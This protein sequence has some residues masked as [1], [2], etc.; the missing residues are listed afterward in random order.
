MPD[1][2]NANEVLLLEARLRQNRKSTYPELS[3]QDYFLISS[4][5]T[6]LSSK[7]LSSRQIEDGIVDGADDGGI[8][9]V[10]LFVDGQLVEDT[11]SM[12][13]GDSPQIE[14]E[15]IQAKYES[16]FKETTLQRLLDHL[17]ILLQLE[18][19]PSLRVEF[20][21]RVLEKFD[22]FRTT[23]LA[24][25]NKFPELTIRIRYVTKSSEAP[26][27]KVGAKQVR[28]INKI[29]DLYSGSDIAVQLVG[30]NDLN[31]LARQRRSRPSTLR[32]SEG[33]ISSDKGGLA[34]LVSLADYFDF[35]TD[36]EGHLRDSLFEDNVRDYEG[37]TIINRGI[38]SSLREGDE[39]DADFW[40]LNNGITVIGKR[41]QPSGKRLDIED[42]QIVNGLQTSRS[43][44]QHFHALG[45]S[46]PLGDGPHSEG[47]LRRLLVRVIETTDDAI[48][49][50]IIKATNSQ[51]RVS[52]ASL[53]SAEPFQRDIEE[54]FLQNGLYY[55][56]KKNHYKN[57]G[58]PRAKIVEVLELAQAVGSVL[59]QQPHVAR[60]KPS[61]LVRGKL[62][63]RVFSEKTPLAA[64]YNCLEIVRSMDS[65]LSKTGEFSGRHDRSNIRFHFA[66]A[67]TAFALLSSRPRPR[68][69]AEID[70][71]VFD[72]QFL[73]K[74]LQW[75][76]E[77]RSRAAKTV[78][79]SDPSV[80]AKAAEWTAQIDGQ[81]S[82]YT[83]KTR[84][85]KKFMP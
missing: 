59:I 63:E 21:P 66:R 7:D 32:L 51:N 41:L 44:Y 72:D 28:L 26:N 1:H 57:L 80:L 46:R 84:W 71:S 10:Y 37:A 4:V 15:I 31:S 64:Y 13:T 67:A 42:P 53:R 85:P 83:A 73:A 69:V 74:V 75:L 14:L 11:S 40:W 48:A 24:T 77:S 5:D 19:E 49:A 68:A 50:K 30:A 61:T 27:E 36:D 17:P 58:K 45:R 22:S 18:I 16:G 62:Y 43:I 60:G 70:L 9:A 12:S 25:A 8:D 81:F 35:I 82:R 2:L 38:A 39:A 55:E 6:L 33:P 78:V 52:A 54:F 56:R 65:Y 76:L 29:R 34:C 20:N 3:E 47:Q 79:S 23:F